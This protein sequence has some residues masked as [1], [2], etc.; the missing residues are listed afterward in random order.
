MFVRTMLVLTCLLSSVTQASVLRGDDTQSAR[1]PKPVK[2]GESVPDFSLTLLDG[3]TWKLSELRKQKRYGKDGVVVLTF[4]CS[5]CHSC[6]HIEKPLDELAKRYKGQ[7]LVLALDASA[8]ET[9]EEVVAFA[10]KKN[11]SLPIG[12]DPDGKSVD[13]FGARTTTTTMVI[14]GKG[15]LRYFGQFGHGQDR[16]AEDALK[17]VLAGDTV[18]VDHTKQRG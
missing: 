4:W 17:A 7:A 5:F 2:I 15:V 18:R 3:K 14:D 8:G 1:R 11:L 10:K 9:I 13:I 12:L 6:R 16:L